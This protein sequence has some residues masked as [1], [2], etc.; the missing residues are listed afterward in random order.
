MIT[1]KQI[2][3]EEFGE[4]FGWR[5]S[6]RAFS[7][8]QLASGRRVPRRNERYWE[9]PSQAVDH[10]YFYRDEKGIPKALAVHLYSPD[11][12]KIARVCIDHSLNFEIVDDK[13][14]SWWNP[15]D[16]TLVI[17]TPIP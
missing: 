14:Q 13:M 6:K 2:R 1:E 5:L 7:L 16:T 12:M 8:D 4:N 10:P 11:P 15:G 17:Y 9:F 3:A